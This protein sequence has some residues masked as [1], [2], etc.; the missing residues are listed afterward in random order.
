[1][2]IISFN[3]LQGGVDDR[4]SRLDSILQ[5][6]EKHSPDFLALQEANRFATD[7]DNL[8]ALF[9]ERLNLP[10]SA[11]ARAP[12]YPD[13][14]YYHVASFSR[15]PI[16][17]SVSKAPGQLQSAALNTRID[18]PLGLLSILNLHLH[19]SSEDA[20]LAELE[21]LVNQHHNEPADLVLGDFNAISRIDGYNLKTLE[22]EARFEV[23]DAL[24]NC[25]VDAFAA[26]PEFTHPTSINTDVR[27]TL[28]RRIDYCFT[29]TNWAARLRHCRVIRGDLA[30]RASDHYP[31]LIE[32]E[33]L[34]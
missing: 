29:N 27:F 24:G 32:F 15:F 16:Q 19:D 11:L 4:G 25:Y 5:L 2:K 8:L 33:P 23:T 22:C 21:L 17:H 31:I 14:L 34:P 26:A 13:G 7:E 6:V 1:M 30:E 10:Y 3:I 18:T 12:R 9:S 20:R 28:P